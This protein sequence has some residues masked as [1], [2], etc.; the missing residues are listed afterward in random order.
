MT[1]LIDRSAT[2][3]RLPLGDGASW[4]D[5][6]RGF[7]PA[8]QELFALLHAET[9][10]QQS[11]VLRYDKYV[12]EKRLGAMVRADT[13]TAV[14][15]TGLHLESKYR[16]KFEGVGAL[17][18]RDGQD[19]QGLHSDREMKWLDD[20]LIG[21]LVLG[22]RRP[23]VLRERK[24]SAN[25]RDR[26]PAGQATDDIDLQ[27]GE[28]DLIVMGGRCQRDW[29]HGVPAADTDQPRIS[30]TW[31]WTSRRGSPDTNPGYFE[32]R[33]FSGRPSQPGYRSRRS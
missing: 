30:L 22:Q 9:R 3:E 25:D 21:I 14:R 13:V 19:F 26:T 28:G 27:P 1:L 18:Y 24:G 23:F 32:G 5:V 4:V 15:Q 12:A 31:R 29:L 6:V 7:V 20:T 11:E 10:W 8:H 33:Q 17:L 16:V 2:V